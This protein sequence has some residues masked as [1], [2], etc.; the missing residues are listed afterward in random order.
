MLVKISV[1]PS[2]NVIY[3][4]IDHKLSP[5]FTTNKKRERV[6]WELSGK[7]SKLKSKLVWEIMTKVV[8]HFTCVGFDRN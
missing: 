3:L 1:L 4:R 8:V 6:Y 5:I 7:I 2:V